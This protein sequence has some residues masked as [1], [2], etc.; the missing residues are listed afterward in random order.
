MIKLSTTCLAAAML[1]T[2]LIA[3]GGGSYQ[4]RTETGNTVANSMD[5]HL[6]E[7][8]RHALAADERVAAGSLTVNVRE[9]VVYI[10]GSPRDSAARQQAVV[11]AR[12][13]P[14]VRSVVD[15]MGFY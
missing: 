11:T 6:A 9:G 13:V 12:R 4:H 7:R 5:L 15:N 3:C 10:S 8:V 1:A 2:T 14:G